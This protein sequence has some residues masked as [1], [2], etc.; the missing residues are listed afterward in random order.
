MSIIEHNGIGLFIETIMELSFNL[1]L[2]L[3]IFSMCISIREDKKHTYMRKIAIPYT[4]TILHFYIVALGYNIAHIV[5]CCYEGIETAKAAWCM[6]VGMFAYYLFGEIF[7]FLFFGVIYRRVI[8]KYG[9]RSLKLWSHILLL[10]QFAMLILLLLNCFTDILYYMDEHNYYNR[11]GGYWIW[12]ANT[13]LTFLYFGVLCV[14]YWEKI[15][16]FLCKVIMVCVGVPVIAFIL[17]VLIKEVVMNNISVIVSAM[18][19]FVMFEKYKT[20]YA[21]ETF[22]EL[23]RMQIK[24]MLSQIQP[25]FL[26]NSLTSII[27]Y[28]DKDPQKTKTALVDFSRYLRKNLESIAREEPVP[29][30]EELE[31]TKKY[32]ALEKLRFEENLEIVYDIE[33]EDFVLPV[34]TLQPLVEN[35]VK[36]GIRKKQNAK[37]T[38]TIRTFRKDTEHVIEVADD[39]AGFDTDMLETCDDTHVGVNNVKKRLM[40]ECGGRLEV[41]SEPGKGTRCRVVLLDQPVRFERSDEQQKGAIKR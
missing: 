3:M 21:V 17:N 28:S 20:M 4:K 12:Y 38:V 8:K 19:V 40:M 10:I 16:L 22:R 5:V 9:G 32:L 27:Y 29:F 30:A 25:H 33:D 24:L 7:V 11:A 34:L 26:Y 31:H 15:D 2:V 6:K 41:E 39:G 14:A 36:H 1:V 23:E 18:I 13:I 37:G 35:A